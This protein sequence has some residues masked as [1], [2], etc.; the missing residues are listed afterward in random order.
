MVGGSCWVEDD[1]TY[2]P[3]DVPEGFPSLDFRP[4]VLKN[5]ALVLAFIFFTSCLA[6][7]ATLLH[8]DRTDPARLHTRVSSKKMV[9]EYVPTL[10]GSITAIYWRSLSRA[11]FRLLPYVKMASVPIDS[12][13]TPK[14][15]VSGRSDAVGTLSQYDY[16]VRAIGPLVKGRHY[17]TLLIHIT[18]LLASFLLAPLKAGLLQ[19][20]WDGTGWTTDISGGISA[21]L[22]FIYSMI[23]ICVI[24]MFFNLLNR[25]TGLKWEPASLA[26][27]LALLNN[28]NC[29]QAF[30]GTEFLNGY[31]VLKNARSW[32]PKY[33]V[34]RLG[35]WKQGEDGPVVHGIR[36][37][38]RRF[39]SPFYFRNK[40]NYVKKENLWMFRRHMISHRCPLRAI[41]TLIIYFFLVITFIAAI[42]C[43]IR[44]II[45]MSS[46]KIYLPFSTKADSFIAKLSIGI[47]YSFLPALLFMYFSTIFFVADIRYR[48][49]QA[50]EG[51]SR[52]GLA[53]KNLL[54]D[55]I[56]PNPAGVIY[57]AVSNGHIYVAWH[58]FLALTSTFSVIVAGQIFN[59]LREPDGKFRMMINPTN[60][61]AAF[62]ILCIY[63]VCLVFARPPANY[64][65]PRL[66]W[67]SILDTAAFVYDSPVLDSEEFDVQDST[68][69]EKHL[70]AKVLLAKREYCFGMYLGRDGRRHMGI[71]PVTTTDDQGRE[72]CV[73]D[74]FQVDW[75]LDLGFFWKC[76]RPRI[77]PVEG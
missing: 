14:D 48:T 28:L 36:F 4:L 3:I 6:G 46:G 7:L 74:C 61:H 15:Q 5:W 25:P 51:L 20:T 59:G 62:A 47:V 29:R 58:A 8:F 32:G 60:F 42:V 54:L 76:R 38:K 68:D 67:L 22:I 37:L 2:Y 64:R 56:S 23:I 11:Y 63:T 12:S 49:C 19:V 72:Q 10:V 17:M 1:R 65:T 75:I 35:Y 9:I 52:P 70:Q 24:G 30:K 27:Q 43:I 13:K 16:D 44:S 53:E 26:S 50:L 71:S 33:G 66:D 57:T 45:G 31:K 18:A 40:S 69:Q 77:V 34:L 21:I 73:V 55:Y 41:T 39:R